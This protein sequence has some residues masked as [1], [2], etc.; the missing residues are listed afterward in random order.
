LKTG[1]LRTIFWMHGP[2]NIIADGEITMRIYQVIED[3]YDGR[4]YLALF[5]GH[6]N[7]TH[8]MGDFQPHDGALREKIEALLNGETPDEWEGLWRH[9]QAG[10][11]QIMAFGQVVADNNSVYRNCITPATQREFGVEREIPTDNFLD[12]LVESLSSH[13]F[14]RLCA[15]C[16]KRRSKD[17]MDT[18]GLTYEE[19]RFLAIGSSIRAV[20]S[21]RQR[22][23][24]TLREAKDCIDMAR[25][26]DVVLSCGL[27]LR[28]CYKM[29]TAGI[30]VAVPLVRSRL[31]MD[32]TEATIFVRNGKNKLFNHVYLQGKNMPT[33]H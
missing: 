25:V 12:E 24:M 3:N 22:T 16:D 20:K 14:D 21:I 6:G 27:T 9:P 23:G 10:Y 17:N 8:L 15:A 28:E 26:S 29:A 7:C 18:N 1:K 33:S 4:L 5:D 2:D 19:N 32:D 30:S 13:M 11:D 31:D